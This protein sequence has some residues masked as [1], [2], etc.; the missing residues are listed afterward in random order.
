MRTR[1]VSLA[2]VV[3]VGALAAT[4][5]AIGA[6]PTGTSTYKLKAALN[7]GQEKPVPKGPKHG[8]SG[9]FTGTLNAATGALTWKLTFK[10]L[11]GDATAAHIHK[12]ARGVPGD[13]VVP[14]CTP[15]TSPVSGVAT[16]NADQVKDLLAGLY[17]VNVHTA[18]NQGGE[19]RGQISKAPT[20]P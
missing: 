11:S 15:C 19:I 14:L 12:G 5:V 7:I 4:S 20:H 8:A 3:T 18:K 1:L 2:V 13:V 6:K 17:Y 9:R 16:L 10:H